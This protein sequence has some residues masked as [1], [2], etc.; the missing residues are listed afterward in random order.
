MVPNGYKTT[1]SLKMSKGHLAIFPLCKGMM[2]EKATLPRSKT[3]EIE[4][5]T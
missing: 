3:V 4:D 5:G 1:N 2:S